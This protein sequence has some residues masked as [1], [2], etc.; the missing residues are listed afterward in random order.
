V[1]CSARDSTSVS[2]V[3]AQVWW[4]LAAA[5]AATGQG[6]AREAELLAREAL[7]IAERTQAP[8]LRGDTLSCAGEVMLDTRRDEAVELLG[9]AIAV[10]EAKGI[11]P[12]AVAT[13]RLLDDRRITVG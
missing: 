6:R 12:G 7:A 2:N 8:H 13:R 3:E 11:T 5:L 4:R 1:A 10:Y 9:Q